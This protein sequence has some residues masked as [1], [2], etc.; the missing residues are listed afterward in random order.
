MDLKTSIT[1]PPYE[2]EITYF[3]CGKGTMFFY[4]SPHKLNGSRAFYFNLFWL[5]KKPANSEHSTLLFDF[6][7][8][9]DTAGFMLTLHDNVVENGTIAQSG[10]LNKKL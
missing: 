7:F 10:K 1:R 8:R 6:K 5:L 2:E 4:L 3:V 9:V